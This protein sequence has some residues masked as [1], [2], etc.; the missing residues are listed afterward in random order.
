MAYGALVPAAVLQALDKAYPG[1]K[2]LKAEDMLKNGQ[3]LFELVIL[4]KDKKMPV[5][6]DP[7]GKIIR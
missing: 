7:T 3:K 2:V 4:V 6:I 5:T 1:C